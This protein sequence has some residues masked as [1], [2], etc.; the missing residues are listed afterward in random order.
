MLHAFFRDK[1]GGTRQESRRKAA[2]TEQMYRV[3]RKWV[4]HEWML[5]RPAG[6]LARTA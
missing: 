5:I 3:Y 6:K 2:G 4:L 1:N